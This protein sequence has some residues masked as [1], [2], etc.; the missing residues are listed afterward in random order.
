M[1]RMKGR[2]RAHAWDVAFLAGAA[3]VMA[4][5]HLAHFGLP[6]VNPDEV[7]FFILNLPLISEAGSERYEYGRTGLYVGPFP[8]QFAPYIGALGAYFSAPF[9]YALGPSVEAVRAYNMFVAIVLQLALYA[10]A[11]EMFS[12]SAAMISVSAFTFFPLVVFYSRQS[13]MYDWIILAVATSMLYFGT[14]FVRGGSAW[15]LGAVVLSAWVIIWAY[16]SSL[17]FVLGVMAALPICAYSYR[18]RGRPITR[19]LVL[20]FALFV[21]LGAVPFVV[22]Y[23]TS[24]HSTIGFVLDT[25]AAAGSSQPTGYQHSSTDNSDI[26]GN[27][28]TRSGHLDILLTRP[29]AGFWAN[30]SKPSWDPHDATFLALF[31]AGVAAA[32][33]EILR[34]GEHRAKM[35]GLL[36]VIA[37]TFVASTF[38][39]SVL[40]PMQLGIMLPLVFLLIGCGVDRLTQWLAGALKAARRGIRQRHV[41]LPVMGLIVASQM[42]HIH[43]GLSVLGDDPAYGYPAASRDLATHVRENGLVPVTMDWLTHKP[44]FVLLRGEFLPIKAFGE[45]E[46]NRFDQSVRDGMRTAESAGLVRNDLLFVIYTY[47]ETLDCAGDLLPSDISHSNQ[48]AQAYFVESAAERNGLDVVVKDFDLPNG[49]PYYRTLQFVERG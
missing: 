7:S 1:M 49:V 12:R 31:V 22:H 10:T 4:A 15:N 38:T 13:V 25:I 30:P 41:L 20:V 23:A 36:V 5:F 34:R 42:P 37:V 3:S 14:K 28:L 26:Y 48:C 39:V 43:D 32:L 47:P 27:L 19:K 11:R 18:S 2:V 17:W 29:G 44:L 45:F 8:V 16:L 6:Q 21:A 35:S 46:G 40:N 24:P 33:A 9:N